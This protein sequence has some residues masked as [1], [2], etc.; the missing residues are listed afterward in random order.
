[1]R[2]EEVER[3]AVR[4]RSARDNQ[5]LARSELEIHLGDVPCREARPRESPAVPHGVED[6]GAAVAETERNPAFDAS[7]AAVRDEI[8]STVVAAAPDEHQT[9]IDERFPLNTR[10][11]Q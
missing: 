9:A 6:R 3:L 4:R 1:C 10:L 5:R 2:R 8:D 11:G 7:V